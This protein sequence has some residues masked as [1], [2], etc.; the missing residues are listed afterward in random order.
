MLEKTLS[1]SN[2]NYFETS[3]Y[4]SLMRIAASPIAS[5]SSFEIVDAADAAL[6]DVRREIEHLHASIVRRRNRTVA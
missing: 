2:E 1:L 6:L 4:T 3:S 5:V